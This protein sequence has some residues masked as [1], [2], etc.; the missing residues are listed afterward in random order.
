LFYVKIKKNIFLGCWYYYQSPTGQE[1]W[2]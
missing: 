2:K 1:W